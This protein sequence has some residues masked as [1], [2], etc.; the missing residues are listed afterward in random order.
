MLLKVS[1]ALQ[2]VGLPV[3]GGELRVGGAGGGEVVAARGLGER[4][5][6]I[7]ANLQLLGA[8][9]ADEPGELR[10]VEILLRLSVGQRLLGARDLEARLLDF[11]VRLAP[12]AGECGHVSEDRLTCLQV[13]TGILDPAPVFPVARIGQDESAC[14]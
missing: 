7:L 14:R 4:G 11:E 1:R 8:G 6:R 3:Q 12:L 13:P 2:H 10:S 9:R 5:E